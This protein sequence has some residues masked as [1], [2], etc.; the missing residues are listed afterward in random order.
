[1]KKIEFMQ[2]EVAIDKCAG[3]AA[4][5]CGGVCAGCDKSS[6]RAFAD[7]PRREIIWD[8]R[9]LL[10]AREQVTILHGDE[11]YQLRQTRQEN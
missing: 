11:R 7:A 5:A 10:Q 3:S 8:S 2:T 1:M 4:P 9:A 6:G